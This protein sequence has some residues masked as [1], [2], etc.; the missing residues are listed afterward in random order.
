MI[1]INSDML[2]DYDTYAL[3]L[4]DTCDSDTDETFD[5]ELWMNINIFN[6]DPNTPCKDC[7]CD[8]PG[9]CPKENDQ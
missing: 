9:S 1:R 7:D 3:N 4:E 6:E 2:D 5:L 8:D